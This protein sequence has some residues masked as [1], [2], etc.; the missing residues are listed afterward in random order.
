M[1]HVLTILGASSATF[2]RKDKWF[3]IVDLL[4]YNELVIKYLVCL[5]GRV[6][7]PTGGKVRDP[8]ERLNRCNSDTDSTV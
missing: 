1:D 8:R 3:V 5:Q 6:K 2:L 7:F 4:R